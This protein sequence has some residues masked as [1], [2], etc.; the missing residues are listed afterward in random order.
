MDKSPSSV[1]AFGSTLTVCLA[2]Q[3]AG[4]DN[5]TLLVTDH[6]PSTTNARVNFSLLKYWR[7]PFR[8]RNQSPERYVVK[9][10]DH[11]YAT[12]EH[13]PWNEGSEAALRRQFNRELE[14]YRRLEPL[15]GIHIPIIYGEYSFLNAQKQSLD[16]FIMQYLPM[17]RLVD[18]AFPRLSAPEYLSKL[19]V[20][21]FSS[22]AKLHSYGVCHNDIHCA[23]M[24][25]ELGGDK[26][27]FV[28]F[29][30]GFWPRPDVDIAFQRFDDELGMRECLKDLGWVDPIPP[31]KVPCM[32]IEHHMRWCGCNFSEVDKNS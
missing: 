14:C 12:D 21:A 5:L 16:L 31:T 15:Q 17:P 2:N 4:V 3:P 1:Y 32:G 23:N 8:K 26:V 27:W 18:H 29:G 25:W 6:I 7:G 20:A 30:N 19:E 11:R 13:D 22:L 10:L 9:L 28:D 24:L